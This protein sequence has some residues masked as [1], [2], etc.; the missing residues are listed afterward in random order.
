MEQAPTMSSGGE[1]SQAASAETF[2]GHEAAFAQ[3][4]QGFENTPAAALAEEMAPEALEAGRDL[5]DLEAGASAQTVLGRG[6]VGSVVTVPEFAEQLVADSTLPSE[7]RTDEQR[8]AWEDEFGDGWSQVAM[9]VTNDPYLEKAELSPE[10]GG[11]V[12]EEHVR[13]NQSERL[14]ECTGLLTQAWD[15][16]DGIERA[17]E[18]REL[19]RV[20]EAAKGLGDLDEQ[21]A[22][23]MELEEAIVEFYEGR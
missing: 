2:G 6:A 14:K 12:T 10:E 17:Q 22:I 7:A 13:R 5:S 15:T 8:Q 20:C 1:A 3:W 4:G 9:E 11:P 21:L 23:I 19:S 18:W 16:V